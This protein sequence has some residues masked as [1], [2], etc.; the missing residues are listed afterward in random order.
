MPEKIFPNY[1]PITRW[2]LESGEGWDGSC[3][4]N[5]TALSRCE[6][7]IKTRGNQ[8]RIKG[9]FSQLYY[10]LKNGNCIGVGKVVCQKSTMSISTNIGADIGTCAESWKQTS[11]WIQ[12]LDTRAG[13][14]PECCLSGQVQIQTECLWSLHALICERPCYSISLTPDC[15]FYISFLPALDW[16]SI[17]TPTVPNVLNKNM[18]TILQCLQQLFHINSVFIHTQHFWL[19][20]MFNKWYLHI[21]DITLYVKVGISHHKGDQS[22][23][24]LPHSRT[25]TLPPTRLNKNNLLYELLQNTSYILKIQWMELIFC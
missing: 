24:K 11:I 8:V 14:G 16:I 2:G 4:S 21:I 9:G 10:V 20:Q 5:V 25:L 17:M 15:C 18:K 13:L 3:Q 23:E 19:T 7:F 22:T 12:I 1:W 6:P